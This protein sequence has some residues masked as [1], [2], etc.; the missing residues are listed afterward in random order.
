[1][2]SMVH[3]KIAHRQPEYYS[4][5]IVA[6]RL[7]ALREEVDAI[8]HANRLYWAQKKPSRTAMAEYEW[9]QKRLEQIRREM[10]KL[11]EN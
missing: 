2:R 1:M 8:H 6:S 10:Q 3:R 7:V 5:M 11:Q 4:S 9:R